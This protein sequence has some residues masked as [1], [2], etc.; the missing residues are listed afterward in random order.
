MWFLWTVRYI[1]SYSY[2]F[3][4]WISVFLLRNCNTK[5]NYLIVHRVRERV[6]IETNSKRERAEKNGKTK[7]RVA[8]AKERGE[9]RENKRVRKSDSLGALLGENARV[10]VRK[11]S[12]LKKAALL[13]LQRAAHLRVYPSALSHSLLFLSIA[14][15]SVHTLLHTCCENNVSPQ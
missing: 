10:C 13:C 12:G 14:S 7:P 3:V 4:W 8:R 6:I 5:R 11:V 2:V 9:E 1:S 15:L